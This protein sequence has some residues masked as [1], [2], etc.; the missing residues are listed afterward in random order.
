MKKR[1][2]ATVMALLLSAAMFVGCGDSSKDDDRSSRS[3]RER[4]YEDDE[5]D[6]SDD[7]GWLSKWNDS[8][9][10]PADEDESFFV[11]DDS[12]PDDIVP[13][14]GF[15]SPTDNDTQTGDSTAP[16]SDS[17]ST[18]N[19]AAPAGNASGV[20]E[21][22]GSAPSADSAPSVPETGSST[23]SA[24]STPNSPTTGSSNT[25]AND[26]LDDLKEFLEFSETTELDD[27]DP[28]AMI[29][30]MQ[31]LVSNLQ[32]K[33][34]EGLAIKADLQDMIDLLNDMM[35]NMENWNEDSFDTA[36]NRIMEISEAA[37]AHMDAFEK[38]ATAAGIDMDSL[39]E[40]EDILGL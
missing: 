22:D 12:E 30:A 20:P 4:S 36:L 7:G 38:A 6:D 16:S 19:S 27:D 32:V 31:S 21:T 2:L 5:E 11:D 17:S 10:D 34:P 40:L 35:L 37:E 29:A 24:N 1:I 39:D 13:S 8:V 14:S 33:T 3:R 18:G 15:T 9:S 26:Y 25:S 23:P 28:V